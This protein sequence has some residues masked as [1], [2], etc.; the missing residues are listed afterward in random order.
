M[1]TVYPDRESRRHAATAR[2]R[3]WHTGQTASSRMLADPLPAIGRFEQLAI[4][5]VH[6]PL[7]RPD[8]H[9]V[10]GRDEQSMHLRQVK[11]HG[12]PA[13]ELARLASTVERGRERHPKR[14]SAPANRRRHLQMRERQFGCDHRAEQPR[15]LDEFPSRRRGQPKEERVAN[16]LAGFRL[17]GS[18]RANRRGTG[19]QDR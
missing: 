11:R 8:N 19:S 17:C 6:Q 10:V 12:P 14:K 3:E 1:T 16:G 5:A 15:P 2:H 13:A 18:T 9:S 7:V 4:A